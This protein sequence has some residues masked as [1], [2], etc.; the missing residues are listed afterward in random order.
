MPTPLELLLDPISLTVFAVYAA[1]M[2]WEAIAPTRALPVADFA[3]ETG[4]YQGASAR[5][6]DM[7]RMRDVS[8][9]N[10]IA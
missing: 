8:R 6:L 5:V 3:A 10:A 4:F 7:L 9:P 2:A 1:L